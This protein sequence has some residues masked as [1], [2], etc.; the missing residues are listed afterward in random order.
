VNLTQKAVTFERTFETYSFET[1]VHKTRCRRHH[2]T[3]LL[4]IPWLAR[5]GL[6][7]YGST[8]FISAYVSTEYAAYRQ[9]WSLLP[10]LGKVE[11]PTSD[12]RDIDNSTVPTN[13][14]R[15]ALIVPNLIV[16]IRLI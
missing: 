9:P 1:Y 6:S 5:T 12:K 7:K 15:I 13:I 10:I 2:H 14:I 16:H 11:Y 8:T 3:V 4:L